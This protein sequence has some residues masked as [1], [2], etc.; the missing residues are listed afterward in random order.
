MSVEEQDTVR[1]MRHVIL[2]LAALIAAA[3]LAAYGISKGVDLIGLGIVIGAVTAPIVGANTVKTMF[4]Q[5]AE[6]QVRLAGKNGVHR[7]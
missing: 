5:K 3:G 1:G 6:T 4:E 2:S 7:D